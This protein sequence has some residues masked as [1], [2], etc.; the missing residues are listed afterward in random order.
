MGKVA[1]KIIGKHTSS[2]QDLS[3]VED[4]KR[5]WLETIDALPDPFITIS[6][7]YS[8]NKANRAMAEIA[9]VPVKELGGKKCYEAFAGRQSPCENCQM[10]SALRGKEVSG[11]EIHNPGNDRWYEVASKKLSSADGKESIVHI[12]RDRTEAKQLQRQVAQHEKLASIGQLAGG[13][14]HEINNPLG[15]IL[16]FSQMLLRE[17]DQSS[18]HYQDV[19]EI[20]AAAKRC[21]TI[22]ENLLDYARQRPLAPTMTD[23]DL[24]TLLKN[25][26]KFAELGHNSGNRCEVNLK[27]N[28]KNNTLH[29]DANRI[30]QVFL[31]LASNG[32]Q[33][34]ASGGILTIETK[35]IEKSGK[36]HVIITVEDEGTGI[37]PKNLAKIFEPFFTTKEPGQGTGLGL[38][39][40]HGILQDLGGQIDVESEFG[41]GTKF[42]VLL[43][44][45]DKKGITKP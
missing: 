16:V 12:Y 20:E 11:Y 10:R 31:N 13:F 27:L 35:D 8:I 1:K 15:G 44:V 5:Q 29:S 22:V 33:A 6:S 43:P 26:V 14:A 32:F 3:F 36:K 30:T 42:T 37:A 34:M 40:V 18:Q 41:S 24:H 28:A 17:M 38:S 7:D 4:L 39:I 25:A 2:A 9:K 23:C 45:S 21:K 19:V